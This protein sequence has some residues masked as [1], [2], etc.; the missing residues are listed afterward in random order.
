MSEYAFLLFIVT[1]F[2]AEVAGSGTP[3]TDLV[4]SQLQ[5]AAAGADAAHLIGNTPSEITR[6]SKTIGAAEAL[7]GMTSACD[8]C[9][10]A[11]NTLQQIIGVAAAL[12]TSAVGASGTCQPNGVIGPTEECDPLAAPSGCPV[13]GVTITYCNDECRCQSSSPGVLQ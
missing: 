3:G 6:L 1:F 5:T 12:K 10:D 13:G 8:S 11:R 4:V 2:A 9:G 7:I